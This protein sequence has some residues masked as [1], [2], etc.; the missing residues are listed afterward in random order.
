[1]CPS[2]CLQIWLLCH[3]HVGTHKGQK[4]VLFPPEGIAR[5]KQAN[6]SA[7]NWTWVLWKSPQL[8]SES[9]LQP[10]LYPNL[11]L[12]TRKDEIFHC[13]ILAAEGS[14]TWNAQ[15]AWGVQFAQHQDCSPLICLA[16]GT[17]F[18][19][20]SRGEPLSSRCDARAWH[21]PWSTVF[22]CAAFPS[23]W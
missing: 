3:M 23:F 7:I 15:C 2:V 10:P 14:C 11:S 21:P 1:M 13:Q 9:P 19:M 6:V 18:S 8:T 22:L 12:R 17:V 5:Y 16:W 4:R 20:T